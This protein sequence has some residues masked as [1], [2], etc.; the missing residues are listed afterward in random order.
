MKR[1]EIYL[2]AKS[3]IWA[4]KM[5]NLKTHIHIWTASH[6][7]VNF[8]WCRQ[9]VFKVYTILLF[10]QLCSFSEQANKSKVSICL[11]VF[12]SWPR[13]LVSLIQSEVH[14]FSINFQSILFTQKGHSHK[15]THTLNTDEAD[16]CLANLETFWHSFYLSLSY[17]KHFIRLV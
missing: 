1:M 7:E 4:D 16:L 3:Q 12:L 9:I 17:V 10:R 14:I 15:H 11:T 6:R 5:E 8:V 13:L 2:M